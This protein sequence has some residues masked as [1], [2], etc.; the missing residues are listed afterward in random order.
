[1]KKFKICIKKNI[2]WR[3]KKKITLWDIKITTGRYKA[4][5]KSWLPFSLF[6]FE[7]YSIIILAKILNKNLHNWQ[8]QMQK[9]WN[10]VKI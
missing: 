5:I 3:L 8:K 10:W 9:Q 1:M 2:F 6:Y 7:A 4:A